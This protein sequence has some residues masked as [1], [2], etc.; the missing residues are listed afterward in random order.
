LSTEFK[1]WNL[2]LGLTASAYAMRNRI[3]RC[4]SAQ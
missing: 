2:G 4:G 1:I 3:E